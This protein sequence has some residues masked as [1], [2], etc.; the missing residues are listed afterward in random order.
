M[1]AISNPNIMVQTS[2]HSFPIFTNK[3]ITYVYIYIYIYILYL[4]SLLPFEL[5]AL[6]SAGNNQAGLT[7][8]VRK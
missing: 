8:D 5:I 6:L 2:V 1:P 7:T 3:S 4:R